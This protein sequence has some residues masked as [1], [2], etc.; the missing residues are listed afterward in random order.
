MNEEF[1]QK[2]R[3]ILLD[4][5]GID[6]EQTR[7][8]FSTQNY[9]FI[10]HGEPSFMIRVSATPKKTRSEIMSELLWVEDLKAFKQTICEPN[11]SLRGERMEEFEIDGKNFRA[12]MFHTHHG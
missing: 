4:R 2:L 11:V 12:C 10:P 3:E 6:I 1:K 9:V 5:Y 7:Y 8:I